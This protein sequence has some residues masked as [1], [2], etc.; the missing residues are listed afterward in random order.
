MSKKVDTRKKDIR[1]FVIVIS[2]LLIAGILL[3][4]FYFI[5][6][7]K[8]VMTY[9]ESSDIDYKVMLKDNEF[10]E[11]NY[12][13]KDKGY[14]ASI[15]DSILIT[16]YNYK[17][18]FSEDVDYDYSY[19]VVAEIDVKDQ[20]NDN[21][22]YHFSEVLSEKKNSKDRGDIDITISDLSV[23]FPKYNNIITTI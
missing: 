1:K 14:I 19:K 11:D 9:K 23:N 4:C 3:L 18:D 15:I 22:I 7:N 12:L 16:N 2:C 10:Y 5:S 21:N 17:V 8:R 6:G 13:D 20:K